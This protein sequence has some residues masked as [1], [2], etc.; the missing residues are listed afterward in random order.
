M[1]VAGMENILQEMTLIIWGAG[2]YLAYC[3]IRKKES[4]F[5]LLSPGVIFFLVG[6]VVFLYIIYGTKLDAYDDFSHWGTAAKVLARYDRFPNATNT[7]ISFTSYPLGTASFI[8]YVTKVV[9]ISSE[10]IQCYAQA[11]LILGMAVSFFAFATGIFSIIAA[12]G[13]SVFLMA[14]NMPLTCL[15]VDTLLPLVAIAAFAFCIYYKDE[16]SQK[17]WYLLPYAIFLISIKNSGIVFVVFLYLYIA[18]HFLK[19]D[20]HLFS[21]LCSVFITVAVLWFWQKHVKLVYADGMMGRH[22]LSITYCATIFNIKSKSDILFTIQ[23]FLKATFSLSNTF[24][25]LVAAGLVILLLSERIWK[26]DTF[27]LKQILGFTVVFY[28]IYQLGLLGMYLFNMPP[29]S[30]TLPSYDR[31]HDSMIIFSTGLFS[32]CMLSAISQ[33]R[34]NRSPLVT[35]IMLA[36]AS[37][38]IVFYVTS[39]H[40]VYYTRDVAPGEDRQAIDTLIE[41]YHIERDRRYFVLVSDGRQDSGYLWYMLQYLLNPQELEICSPASMENW[42]EDHCFKHY[43]Y[44]I[45]FEQTPETVQ[46]FEEYFDTSDSVLCTIEY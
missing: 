23:Q 18:Y 34:I 42:L 6:S 19:S 35:Q 15:H 36:V 16:L 26:F 27:L 8:Y 39:P 29:D 10:W 25:Y 41:N 5:L 7:S 13:I 31:Y 21:L 2:V 3:S 40:M 4:P 43:D 33:I 45:L 30:D 38:V 20:T 24:F 44:F 28:C 12:V 46:L 37:V 11:I 14:S 22:S 17:N 1:F 32:I 9:G